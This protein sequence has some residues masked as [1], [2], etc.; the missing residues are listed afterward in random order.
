[1]YLSFLLVHVNTISHCAGKINGKSHGYSLPECWWQSGVPI[2]NLGSQLMPIE[3]PFPSD[4]KRW[5]STRRH[6][7]L[8][9]NVFRGRIQWFCIYIDPKFTNFI[10][11]SRN[12]IF[13]ELFDTLLHSIMFLIECLFK[14][15]MMSHN[16]FDILK[17]T[18]V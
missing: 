17:D 9:S 16:F 1:M 7:L 12:P 6:L 15:F 4:C 3:R 13:E 5:P 18:M 2:I 11:T 8:Y 14:L 10:N